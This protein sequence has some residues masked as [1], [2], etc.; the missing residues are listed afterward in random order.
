MSVQ[1][2]KKLEVSL[3]G[4]RAR[5]QLR[6]KNQAN[7]WVPVTFQLAKYDMPVGSVWLIQQVR[8]LPTRSRS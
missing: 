1:Y 5:Q 3:D 2:T 7:E 4:K 8:P 6:L